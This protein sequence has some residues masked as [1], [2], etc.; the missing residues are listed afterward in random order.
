MMKITHILQRC[1]NRKKELTLVY[2]S[3]LRTCKFSYVSELDINIFQNKSTIVFSN[4]Q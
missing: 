2:I 4:G 3:G 1:Y